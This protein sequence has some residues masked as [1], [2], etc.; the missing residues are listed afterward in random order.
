MTGY[1]SFF[2]Y[3]FW[4]RYKT[5][6]R[7]KCRGDLMVIS[8]ENGIWTVSDWGY[9]NVKIWLE[10]ARINFSVYYPNR[11]YCGELFLHWHAMVEWEKVGK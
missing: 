4:I 11:Y 2:R 6:T 1:A 10:N 9:V 7:S 8:M 3:Q 5:Y